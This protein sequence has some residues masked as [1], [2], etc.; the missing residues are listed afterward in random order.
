M[1]QIVL[2]WFSTHN[3]VFWLLGHNRNSCLKFIKPKL[4]VVKKYLNLIISWSF[5][6]LLDCCQQS[7]IISWRYF[8][9]G[10]T[11]LGFMPQSW[12]FSSDCTWVSQSRL[13]QITMFHI[14]T[15]V[16]MKSQAMM[17]KVH[18]H[19]KLTGPAAW[20]VS[21]IQNPLDVTTCQSAYHL[22]P[23]GLA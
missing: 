16:W 21:W 10:A 2:W 14:N 15:S 4:W 3:S 23:V 22:P 19:C 13:P 18:L 20:R 7:S 5:V 9:W 11:L 12:P 17:L 8:A 1:S 6:F